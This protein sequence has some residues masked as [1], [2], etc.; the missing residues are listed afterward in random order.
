[1]NANCSY[2]CE[3]FVLIVAFYDMP[4]LNLLLCSLVGD[5]YID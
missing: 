4:G 1:M 5:W 3:L 2:G